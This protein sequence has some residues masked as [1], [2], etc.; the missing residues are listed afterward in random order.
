MICL[1][2]ATER[3]IEADAVVFAGTNSA[4]DGLS[5]A[6]GARKIVSAAIGDCTAAR[7]AA[8]AIHNGRKAALSL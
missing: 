2:D 3:Q 1:L 8:F 4:A 7:Q 5:A 6:R